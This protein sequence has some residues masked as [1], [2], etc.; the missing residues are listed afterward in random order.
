MLDSLER[1]VVATRAEVSDVYRAAELGS[2]CTMLSGETAQGQF[3]VLAVETMTNIVF[4]SEKHF[5]C[6][7]FSCKFDYERMNSVSGTLKDNLNSIRKSIE[8][9]KTA[10][11]L[12]MKC[13]NVFVDSLKMISN[14]R[15]KVPM[16]VFVPVKN[17]EE[18]CG[19]PKWSSDDYLKMK[20]I[21]DLAL[22]RGIN[23]V[24]VDGDFEG[25]SESE[26][27]KECF[28]TYTGQECTLPILSSQDGG[29]S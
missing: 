28:K 6:E 24:F 11:V 20:K 7:K 10:S 5:N 15:L 26:M 23:L 4:E 19:S 1:N 29:L 22:C 21:S 18:Y 27:F 8:E 17:V 2:D 9:N 25:A 13:A 16:F 14:L 12:V 3:P